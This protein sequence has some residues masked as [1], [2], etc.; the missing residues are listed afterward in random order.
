MARYVLSTAAALLAVLVVLLAAGGRQPHVAVLEGNYDYARGDLARALRH[1]RGAAHAGSPVVAYNLANARLAGGETD[2]GLELLRGIDAD[3]HPDL[4]RRVA[5]NLGHALYRA[6]RYQEAAQHFRD[7]LALDPEWAAAR[8]NLELALRR[9]RAAPPPPAH[10]S[11][12]T[13]DDGAE[14]EL[15]ERFGA[16]PAAAPAVPAGGGTGGY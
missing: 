11:G 16:Q 7:A 4:R 15:L 3:A 2:A 12:G 14:A 10:A 5:F 1:Y 6:A 9:M 13:P 8:I